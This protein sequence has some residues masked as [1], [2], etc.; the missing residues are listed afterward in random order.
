MPLLGRVEISVVHLWLKFGG[1]MLCFGVG[2]GLMTH[3]GLPLWTNLGVGGLG[4]RWVQPSHWVQHPWGQAQVYA[5]PTGM[6][7]RQGWGLPS[8]WGGW[9]W[10]VGL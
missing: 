3:V 7:R 6:Q 2:W 10:G 4:N 1:R 5:G 9:G 8:R